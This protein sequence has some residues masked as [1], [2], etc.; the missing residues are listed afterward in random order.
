[1]RWL[2]LALVLIPAVAHAHGSVSERIDALSRDLHA[3][4]NDARLL[5][6]RG[7]LYALEGHY[8]DAVQEF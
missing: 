6:D 2:V 5:A 4:P 7:A 1:M 3:Q 8:T